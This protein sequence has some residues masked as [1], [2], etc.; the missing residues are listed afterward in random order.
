MAD[1]TGI[2]DFKKRPDY[3]EI[4]KIQAK[5]L[6][7]LLKSLG[8]VPERIYPSYCVGG[9]VRELTK[10]R[11]HPDGKYDFDFE[12]PEDRIS[13]EA[14][15]EVGVPLANFIPDKTRTTFLAL[16]I[17]GRITPWGYR[18]E[19]YVDIGKGERELLD[20]GTL[21]YFLWKPL[22]KH[23]NDLI[24]GLQE[25]E[26]GCSLGAVGLE[27]LCMVANDLERIQDVDYIKPFYDLLG[28]YTGRKN[29]MLGENLRALHRVFS[30]VKKYGLSI[31]KNRKE[32]IRRMKKEISSDSLTI[33]Q[34]KELLKVHAETQPWHPELEA[35]I[36]STIEAIA[37]GKEK[38][39]KKE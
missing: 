12:V 29:Y 17:F 15:L 7:E 39:W 19:V 37:R 32:K 20:V 13:R 4:Q 30:D 3:K 6:V 1:I 16:N 25:A 11:A 36:V 38:C 28:K 23:G 9:P 14:F 18:N 5:N 26:F 24:T 34:I 31:S 21:E 27:R 2:L 33:T 22:Q 10:D 8:I 35:G